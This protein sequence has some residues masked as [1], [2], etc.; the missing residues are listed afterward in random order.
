MNGFLSSI[1]K[2]NRGYIETTKLLIIAIL[3][4]ISLFVSVY[5]L[6]SSPWT[7]FRFIYVFI[8]HLY[9]I[10]IILLALWYPKSGIRLLGTILI[11]VCVFW[12]VSEIK[13]SVF[14]ISFVMLYSGL[15]LATIMVLLLYVKD[16]RLVEAIIT[17]I[18]E[19]RIDQKNGE[20]ITDN[21][22][23]DFDQIIKGIKS[24]DESI[25][26]DAVDALSSLSDPRA[27]LP[28]ISLLKDE[29][30]YVRRAAVIA[31]SNSNSTKAV[32]A[33]IRSLAD[34]DRYVREAAAKAL[35]LMG[36]IALPY[37]IKGLENEEW[38]IRLGC[39]ISLRVSSCRLSSLD[40]V[41]KLISDE[42]VYVRREA[43]KTLGRIG[44]RAILPY[45]TAATMDED[46]GVRLRSIRAVSK[47]GTT[48]DLEPILKRAL[49]DEDSA[50]RMF[51]RELQK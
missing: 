32:K 28:L 4:L 10:P 38:R 35:G 34:D 7:G 41:L 33:L 45:L 16:R 37:I 20:N 25:R 17:D 44:N 12:I 9:L 36:S 11:C 23:G 50:V 24:E 6:W 21:F 18:I 39:V 19:R 27:L 14:S 51:A 43:V 30:S 15:D 42:S 2:I 40:V 31:V 46:S 13:G 8:P 47:I 22:G 26:E 49:C 3:S 29:S 1:F 48:Q 5:V